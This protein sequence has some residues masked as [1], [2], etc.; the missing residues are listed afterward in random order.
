MDETDDLFPQ[1]NLSEAD[2]GDPRQHW[3]AVSLCLNLVH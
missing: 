3:Y 1:G 2:L